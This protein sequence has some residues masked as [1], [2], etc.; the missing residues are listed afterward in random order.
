MNKI[1][2]ELPELVEDIDTLVDNVVDVKA[3]TTEFTPESKP[4]LKT[5]PKAEPKTEATEEP[6]ED[7]EVD[8]E[9]YMERFDEIEEI[10]ARLGEFIDDLG[11]AEH[12]QAR[13]AVLS[14]IVKAQH[15][16][17]TDLLAQLREMNNIF[18]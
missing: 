13:V 7:S 9:K 6:V 3:E 14:K 1:N 2:K 11:E 16:L 17:N 10:I 4:E 5:E 18:A 12:D 15:L 8:V